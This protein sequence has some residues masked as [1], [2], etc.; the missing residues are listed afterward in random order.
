MTLETTTRTFLFTDLEGSTRLWE[1]EPERMRA[2]VDRH[3]DLLIEAIQTNGGAVLSETGDGF[4]A[5]FPTAQ[6]AL[7]AALESQLA[8]GAELWHLSAPLK[9]RVAVHTDTAPM[10]GG[11][12]LSPPLNRASRLMAAAHGGQVVCS[13]ATA[14][15]ARPSLGEGSE[16]VD[17]GEYRLRDLAQPTHIFQ[18]V[19]PALDRNFPLLRTLDAYPTNLPIQL[20]GFIG[21]DRELTEVEKA[22]EEA[23]VVTLTGVGGVGKTRLAV[24]VAADVIPRYRDGAW[25]VELAPAVEP[26]AIV[27]VVASALGVTQRQGQTLATS[28][29]D[30]FRAKQLLLIMDNCEHLLDAVARFIDETVH[31]CPR[32]TIL[33]TSRE[34]LGVGGERIIAVPS[35][36]L[37]AEHEA[38]A[39]DAVS[40]ESVRLFV[41]RAAEAKAGF[42]VTDANQAQVVR[43]CRRLDG[44]PLAIELAA[45]RVRSL[46]PG[47]LADRLDAR[48]RLLAGGPRTAVERHQT[49]RRAIDWSYD[50][51]SAPEQTVMSRLAVFAG[52][53]TL[54]A[55]EAVTDGGIIDSV[56]VIDLL[57]HLVDKSLLLAEEGDEGSR[58]RLLETIRQYAQERLEDAEEADVYRQRHALYYLSFAQEAGRGM[59][60]SDEVG[61]TART[62]A[63]LD[64]LRAALAWACAN[65][66]VQLAFRLVT[67][68]A[69]HGTRVGYATGAWAETVIALPKASGD[70]LFPEVLAWAGWTA[71]LTGDSERGMRL[72]EDAVIAAEQRSVDDAAWCSVLRSAVGVLGSA[73]RMEEA[74]VLAERWASSARAIGDDYELAQALVMVAMPKAF[75]GDLTTALVELDEAVEVARR[76]GN[77]TALTYTH[78][79]DGMIRAETELAR[80]VELLDAALE[81]ATEVGNQLGMGVVLQTSAEAHVRLG[82][83][84]KAARLMLRG[85]EH[86]YRIGDRNFFRNLL[87]PGMVAFTA[88][89]AYEASAVVYGAT[90]VGQGVYDISVFP[91]APWA[92]RFRQALEA[93]RARLGEDFFAS[94]VGRG[95]RM[96]DEE[97]L[98]FV[99]VEV[100]RLLAVPSTEGNVTSPLVT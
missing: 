28:I 69:L 89:N 54:N 71:L 17:L 45:A 11:R 9:A 5:V 70:P 27:E 64:N 73:F 46:T 67:S 52:S 3:D 7:Q 83:W 43:L 13:E 48:F 55:A 24:Q 30:F 34:G 37:P 86:F 100:D 39:V 91:D 31:D 14:V 25:I 78:M 61:W 44:I 99:R 49:L 18:L 50:L 32:V 35:L 95:S 81:H 20:T 16:L 21:R 15:L 12:Y 74:G 22:L 93:D 63:E 75:A 29:S 58:Y 6:G 40:A 82:D 26:G 96:E 41:E 88:A 10:E 62:E 90:T 77:P 2:A 97:V 66:D 94:C 79:S 68:L 1:D 76:L 8:L 57:G 33:S 36:G 80:G 53:F 59:R 19:H 60:G 42:V 84:E 23:R 38:D 65:V 47:E 98:A 85:L 72:V 51:L 87:A 56:D 92:N 4:V